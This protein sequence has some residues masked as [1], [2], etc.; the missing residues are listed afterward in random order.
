MEAGVIGMNGLSVL[1][2]ARER[3]A[4]VALAANVNAT[5]QRP[6]T[7]VNDVSVIVTK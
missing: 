4:I 6:L 1:I 7:V 3:K 2:R 5:G